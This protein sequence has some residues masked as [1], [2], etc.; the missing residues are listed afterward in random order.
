MSINEWLRLTNEI[1]TEA[2]ETGI[3]TTEKRNKLLKSK[4]HLKWV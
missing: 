4:Q 3:V 2:I 1:C